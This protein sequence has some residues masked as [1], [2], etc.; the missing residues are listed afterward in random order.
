[1]FEIIKDIDKDVLELSVL[2]DYVKYLVDKLELSKC[3]IF[4]NG[5]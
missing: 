3:D 4:C 1:M 2:N 5:R